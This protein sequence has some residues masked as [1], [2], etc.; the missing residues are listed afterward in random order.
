MMRKA[1]MLVSLLLALAAPAAAAPAAPAVLPSAAHAREQ[2][3]PPP[4]TPP[5]PFAAAA[6]PSIGFLSAAAL[7]ERC[8]ATSAGLVSYCFA[9]ITGVHDTVQ[10]YETWLRMRE[11]CAPSSSS[12][13]EMRWAFLGY[14]KEHPESESGEAASVVVLA[15]KNRFSC[16]DPRPADV[17]AKPEKTTPK[18]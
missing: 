5:E 8:E 12:Q 2:S 17:L 9:Y 18:H 7:R 10:A 14:L 6:R 4:S 3:T 16:I 11:F 15:L 13:G 1:R